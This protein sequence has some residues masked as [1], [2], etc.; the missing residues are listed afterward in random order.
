M[1][2]SCVASIEARLLAKTAAM[3]RGSLGKLIV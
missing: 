2:R 3:E 1:T